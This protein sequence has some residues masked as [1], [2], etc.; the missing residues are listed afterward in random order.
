MISHSAWFVCAIILVAL[1]F[2]FSNGFHDAANSIATVV[3][4]RVLSPTAAV[5]WAGCFN[6]IAVFVFGTAVAKT[7]GKGL[8]DIGV[9]DATVVL[10]GLLGA[11]SWNLITWY[12]GL[13]SSSSHALIGGYAGAAIA[14]AGI[15]ALLWPGK[16]VQTLAFIVL[17]PMLGLAVAFGLTVALS[18]ILRRSLPR[19][20]DKAFRL[21]Q[22]VSAAGMSLS[23]G[24][25]DSQKTMGIIVSLLFAERVVFDRV[26]VAALHVTSAEAI[27]TWVV[28]AAYA[29]I[30]I[31]TMAGGWRI[32]K[33]MGQR[34]TKL[35]PFGGFC[36]ES[37]G[38]ITLF[39]AS[40]FGIPVSTT[41]TITGAISG[42][43]AAH[44][45]SAV[46]WG[47]AG[48]IVWAWILTIPAAA[49][50]AG[51]SYVVLHAVLR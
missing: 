8:V 41:H 50:I 2:D 3:S 45:L 34:I 7:M 5:V 51:L 30:G 42:V 46:R 49:G 24:S 28:F 19:K 16:W 17:S 29:A 35:Q 4:T 1:I 15:S 47:V 44:R 18:W 31:G 9:V 10:A 48:R 6:F 23:H 22:L 25:N 13:P 38:A 43:G 39:V 33:T 27:P 20:V 37:G 21:L 40:H 26:P 12:A 11:I 36:A 14:K 32:V